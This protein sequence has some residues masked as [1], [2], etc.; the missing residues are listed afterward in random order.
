MILVTKAGTWMTSLKPGFI[1]HP[2]SNAG[3]VPI[4][5]T[6]NC[7]PN[8]VVSSRVSYH[9]GPPPSP[10]TRLAALAINLAPLYPWYR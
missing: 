4:V 6:L 5:L 1:S 10:L 3:A 7:I 2:K 9:P 8:L